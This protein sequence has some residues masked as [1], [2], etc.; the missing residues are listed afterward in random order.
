ML[1]FIL[2][3][4]LLALGSARALAGE[5]YVVEG[6]V[7]GL[8]DGPLQLRKVFDGTVLAGTAARDG[9]FVFRH[10]GPF[11]GDKVSLS[12]SGVPAT[13]FY[14]EPGVITLRGDVKTGI[15][16]AGTPSNDAHALY[17]RTVAPVE[18]RIHA[19]RTKLRQPGG[20]PEAVKALQQALAYKH[21]TVFY[22]LRRAFALAHNHTILA[23]EFLSAGTGQLTYTDMST[24][25]ANLDPDTPEN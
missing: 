5:G 24:L 16:A 21:D 12:G 15:V 20:D 11:L 3:L 19:L 14:L 6:H 7:T 22:P 9:R 4:A 17:L 10:D 1:I 23:A 25:V 18:Q 13:S 8:P 2:P